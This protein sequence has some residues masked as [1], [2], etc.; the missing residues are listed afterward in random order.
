MSYF[1][2]YRMNIPMF[3]PSVE[4]L[5]KWDNRYRMY[6]AVYLSRLSL[7]V[8]VTQYVCTREYRSVSVHV[9]P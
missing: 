7:S 9:S 2:F 5:V 4:L 6:V 8:Y 3:F 1:E